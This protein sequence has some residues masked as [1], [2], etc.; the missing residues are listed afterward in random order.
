MESKRLKFVINKIF[1]YNRYFLVLLA[2]ISYSL[3]G[4]V[5]I[6]KCQESF[7]SKN[8]IRFCPAIK[9]STYPITF[10]YKSYPLIKRVY[11]NQT[12]SSM[13]VGNNKKVHERFKDLKTGFTFNY[14]KGTREN[15]GY[16]ILSRANP[17]KNGEPAIELWDLNN[18]K[19]IFEWNI[20]VQRILDEID[21]KTYK[22]NSIYFYNPLLLKDGSIVVSQIK[23][24]QPLIKIS[25][26]GKLLKFNTEF[27]FHHSLEIDKNSNRIYA[28]IRRMGRDPSNSFDIQGFATIDTNLNIINVYSLMDIFENNGLNYRIYSKDPTRD[29]FHLNDVQPY[30][31]LIGKDIVLL[32]LRSLSSIM[33][34]D[35][36][37]QKIL[38][39]MEGYFNQQHDVDILNSAGSE[40]SVFDNNVKYNKHTLGNKFIIFRNLPELNKSSHQ[41]SIKAFSREANNLSENNIQKIEYTFSKVPKKLQ[42]QTRSSGTS[43]YIKTNDSIFIEDSNNGYSFEYD[44]STKSILWTYV[45][46][47]KTNNKYFRMSWSRRLESLPKGLTFEE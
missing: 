41:K 27:A 26:R 9:I 17:N 12:I 40:I 42:P 45:N 38:W 6:E 16:I 35:L 4:I 1:K 32:S 2:S 25:S 47:S 3:A 15:A 28:P 33:A 34:F 8:K 22:S 37:R 29:P 5:A 20:N 23:P 43:E 7:Y 46:R 21:I 24:G 44:I 19:K 36:K 31:N 13:I 11:K 39:I 30:E 14:K 18:Q 10:L